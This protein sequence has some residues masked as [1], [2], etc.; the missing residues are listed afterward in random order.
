[1]LSLNTHVIHKSSGKEL[2]VDNSKVLDTGVIIYF[3]VEKKDKTK[4]VFVTEKEIY[5]DY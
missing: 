5:E 3:L 1:M 2:V 4:R